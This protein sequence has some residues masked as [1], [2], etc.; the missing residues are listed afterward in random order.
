MR[1]SRNK[2][3]PLLSLVQLV[4]EE[5]VEVVEAVPN[6]DVE[7]ASKRKQVVVGVVGAAVAGRDDVVDMLALVFG[8]RVELEQARSLEA[9]GKVLSALESPF[10]AEVESRVD[11]VYSPLAEITVERVFEAQQQLAPPS[12]QTPSRDRRPPNG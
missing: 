9:F 5:A 11:R 10:R 7:G 1:M 6:S 4:G 8:A 12:L 2:S 3:W